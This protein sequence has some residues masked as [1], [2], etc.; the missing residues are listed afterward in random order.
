MTSRARL[1]AVAFIAGLFPAA[2]AAQSTRLLHQPD[3]SARYVAFAYAGDIWLAPK[4]GDARRVT[5]SPT[6]ESDP[7]FSPEGKWLAFTGE[8]GGNPDVYVVGVDGGTPRRLTW[9]P[10]ADEVRGWTPDGKRVV[11]MSGRTGMPDGEP[12]L[13][14]VPVTG[15]LPARLPV[16]RAMAGAI[17]ADGQEIAYQ[18][19]RPWETEMRNY[20]GG[21]NQPIRVLDVSTHAM[22]KLPWT[23]SRDQQPVWLGSTIYFISDRDWTNN[24]WSYDTKTKALKQITHYADYEVESVNTGAGLVAY[25]QAGDVHVY[26]P[27]TGQ[28]RKLAIN[29]TGD[30]PW[31]MPHAADISKALVA[32]QLSP[33]GVR[34]LF[35][36]RGDVITVPTDKGTW[37]NLTNSS[38]VADR[39]PIWSPDGKQIAWF[40]DSTGEYELMVGGQDGLTPPKAYKLQQPTYFYAPAWSPDGKKILFTDAELNLWV[41]DLAT[42]KET[43]VDQG[44][45][46]WPNRDLAPAWSPD[47][48]WVAYTKRLLGSQFH[49][50]F[51]YNVADHT[52]HQLTDGLSD[53]I[54]PTWD[55]SGKYL[56]FLASTDFALHTGWLDMSSYN[57]PIQRG[58]YLA[59]LSKAD[60]SPL[61]PQPGDETAAPAKKAKPDSNG[62]AAPAGDS[63]TVHIDFDGFSQ[64]ILSLDVPSREYAGLQ[65][66]RAGEF[67]YLENVPNHAAVLHRY[68]LKERKAIDFV[69]AA[70]GPYAL[71]FDGKKLLY[72][73]ASPAGQ[74]S[75]QWAVVDATGPVPTAGKGALA[76]AGLKVEVD[77]IAEWR[78]IF[79]EA[80]RIERDYLYVANMNGADWP[81]IKKKY[82]VLL[83]YVRHRADLT[84]LLSEMQ[85]ELTVGHSFAGGGDLPRADAQPAGLLGADLEVSNG[86]YRIAKIYTGEN[87]NPSLRAPLSAPGV[88]VHAGDYILSVNGRNLAPPENPYAA[89][90]GTVGQQVQLRVNDRPVMDGSRVITVVP[91][92]SDAALRTRDWIES[93]RRT[94][95][96]LS[97]GQLAY[98]YIPD[99]GEGGYT[100]FN[101]YYFAQQ[102]KK[103]AVI[104]ERF[105]HGGSIADYMVDIMTRQLHGYFSQRLGNRYDAVTA[106]A[107]AIWGPKVLIINEMSGSGGD[108]FPY[109]FHQMKIGPLIGTKTWG[110]LVGWGGEPRLL[111]GGFISAPST[112]FYNPD[113]QWDVENKGV[114]PDI[115][116]EQ[117]PAQRLAGHDP[118]LER[119]V[120]EAMK[121]LREHPVELKKVP[122]GPDRV[123]PKGGG[124]GGR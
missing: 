30:F 24:V 27:A 81:A 84:Q 17:S 120:A 97:D 93:N 95:D 51:V 21:Q 38:G 78:Q 55:K 111:D 5:S 3:V 70:A 64:R 124:N 96:S 45:Y 68:D 75:G 89:F 11:F 12:Q 72:E 42:G 36:A 113:G 28:D 15:G 74:P 104:D 23:N 61:L 52:V 50:V 69:P 54:D 41:L 73:G 88:D 90:V 77:P 46:T 123:H 99:T 71:S 44:N 48:R 108:M 66:G 86:R 37:R 115:E 31:A 22:T 112:G 19:V 121:L 7:H 49:A 34:A 56:L 2:L 10:G 122:A 62:H 80:W 110:G 26:D 16:P 101:R 105:N 18:L 40:S 33:T 35:E 109:M 92:A 116:V 60:S 117:T 118:Q 9:H 58:V 43:H 8:Y 4:D 119:A 47:S 13:W 1:L 83:P 79:D 14:T 103:G 32:P 87:W 25:E 91:V 82:E 85:G 6:V 114:P 76:T 57:Q 100:N 102:N 39:T 65:A 63:A 106:P 107:A 59:V 29:V 53:V 94:V 67:F 20:R 98:I